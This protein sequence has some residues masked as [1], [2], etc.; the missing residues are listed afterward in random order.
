MLPDG[1]LDSIE[2]AYRP[3]FCPLSIGEALAEVRSFGAH[4]YV[5]TLDVQPL[6][7]GPFATHLLHEARHIIMRGQVRHA[8]VEKRVEF[9]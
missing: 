5:E 3:Q 7:D 8:R 9:F 4:V 1:F 2:R 6:P